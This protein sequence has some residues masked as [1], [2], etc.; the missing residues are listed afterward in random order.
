MTT[1]FDPL[2]LGDLNLPNRIIMAPLTRSRAG[3]GRIANHLMAEYYAQRA[4]AGLILSEATVVSPMGIGYD[5]T[6]GIWSLETGRRLEAHHAGG[7]T[8]RGAASSCSSGTWAAYPIRDFWTARCLW[9]PAQSQ[10][11]AISAWCGLR[12]P[13]LRRAPSSATRSRA[14]SRLS[15]ERRERATCP[16]SMASNCME[17]MAICWI[18]FCRTAPICAPTTMAARSRTVRG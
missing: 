5:D 2:K 18:N 15:A 11:K 9:R 4:S 3:A 1:L 14:S 7:C 6:P 10:P 12:L 16:A 13:S 8:G 17:P